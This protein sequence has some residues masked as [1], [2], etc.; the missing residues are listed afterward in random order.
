MP[1]VGHTENVMSSTDPNYFQAL[2]ENSPDILCYVGYDNCL[3]YVSPSSA[4]LL[5][6]QPAELIGTGPDYLVHADDMPAM[7]AASMANRPCGSSPEPLTVRLRHKSGG[8]RWLEMYA[9]P[10]DGS[11]GLDGTVGYKAV[12]IMRDVTERK[13]IEAQLEAMAFTDGLTGLL[14][15]RGFD[16]A[17]DA[18]W[19]MTL[20]TGSEIS[21]LLLDI[22]HFKRFNDGFGHQAGDDCLRAVAQ[23]ITA[24]LDRDHTHAARY[25]GEEIAVILPGTGAEE[26]KEIGERLRRAVQELGVPNAP[27]PGT[28]GPSQITVSVGVAT[29]LARLG[30]SVRM[31]ETLLVTAD[32]ALYNAKDGGRNRI[33]FKLLMAS[34]AA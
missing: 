23:A 27:G 6:W 3:E 29:A 31:P 28:S 24:H 30:A 7:M 4:R 12:M 32:T 19:D 10:V 8:Y 2:A 13:R 15:R 26:A 14:N 1:Y 18:A 22:D 21:L 11:D 20:G 25:G 33:A 34:A 5:G 17:L 9:R 16:R